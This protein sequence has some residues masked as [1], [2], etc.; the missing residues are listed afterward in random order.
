MHE[1]SD[2]LKGQLGWRSRAGILGS[3]VAVGLV[4]AGRSLGAVT[5]HL[6]V[7]ERVGGTGPTLS[8]SA[9]RQE[10]D[11]PAGRIQV[12]VPSGFTLNSPLIGTPVGSATA[13]VVVRDANPNEEQAWAGT[14]VAISPTDPS[15]AYEG[16]GCDP[17]QH[18]ATWMVRLKGARGSLSF[19][20]FV[21]ST[22]DTTAGFGPYVLVACF[23][24]PDLSPTDPNRSPNGVVVDSFTV[25][26]TSFAAPTTVGSYLWRSLWTPFAPGTER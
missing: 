10:S 3:L 15:V 18:L 6:V 9:S 8:I 16:S 2:R 5:P 7:T 13:R 24:P 21:D 23:R 11:D 12:F 14:V 25:A 20:I 19:P 4:L 26:L 17:D 1:A 22:T